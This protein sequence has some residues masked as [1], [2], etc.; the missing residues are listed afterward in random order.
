MEEILL[1]IQQMEE[2][3]DRLQEC[4]K[5]DPSGID[6][7]ELDILVDYYVSGRWLE[8]YELDEQGYFPSDLKRGV[9]SEDGLYDFLM[10]LECRD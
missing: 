2:L 3:F 7:K 5:V 9:L 1:R 4:A 6:K 10:G 8:D